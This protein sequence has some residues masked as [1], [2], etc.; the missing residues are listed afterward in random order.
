VLGVPN[1]EVRSALS[2]LLLTEATPS[3]KANFYQAQISDTILSGNSAILRDTVTAFLASIPHDWHRRNNIA[4]F[5]GYWS[6]VIY[7]LFAGLGYDVIPE[8]TTNKGRIDMTVKTK[9]G[10]WIFEFKVK[11]QDT[12]SCASPLAQLRERGYALKYA[13]SVDADSKTIPV[14]EVG[15]VFDPATRNIERWEMG[16]CI[17]NMK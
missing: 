13:G 14:R 12:S 3:D 6:T 4:K 10:I 16:E 11:G 8:D 15:I 7:T 2:Q 1:L 9:Q 17:V 5:E